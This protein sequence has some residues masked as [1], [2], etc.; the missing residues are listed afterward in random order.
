MSWLEERIIIE[1]VNIAE[2][3]KSL[4]VLN[5]RGLNLQICEKDGHVDLQIWG[6]M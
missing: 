6:L 3:K 1:K 5:E 4:N 2:R